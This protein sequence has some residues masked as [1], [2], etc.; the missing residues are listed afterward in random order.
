M[1][2]AMLRGNVTTPDEPNVEHRFT[3]QRE[4]SDPGG[5]VSPMKNTA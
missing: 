5:K 4:E 1:A 2:F 3:D